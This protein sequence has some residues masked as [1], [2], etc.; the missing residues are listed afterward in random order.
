[1]PTYKILG[2]Y[3]FTKNLIEASLNDP[4]ILKHE[5]YNIKSKNAIGV[6]IKNDKKIGY[7]PIENNSELLNFKNS[8]KINKLQLNQDYALVEINRCYSNINTLENYEFSYIKK[9]KYNYEI[10]D[11][12][13][14]LI[15][16]LKN[17][18]NNLKHKRITAK[19]IA[20]IYLD[21]DFINLSIETNKGIETFYLISLKFFK[22]NEEKYEELLEFNLIEHTFFQELF[23]HRPEKYIEINYTNIL[24]SELPLN[25]CEFLKIQTCE[26]IN[27]TSYIDDIIYF[28]KLYIYCL[29]IN[30]FTYIIKYTKKNIDNDIN[31]SIIKN[32]F[33]EYKLNLGG[34][35][36]NHEKKIYSEIDFIND[37]SIFII[38]DNISKN[39]LLNYDLTDKKKILIYNP[40]E[41]VIYSL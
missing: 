20:I 2:I 35:Y 26:K 13:K 1:M 19:R 40:L 28:T 25:N 6:Y 31:L 41:G 18:L 17:V 10:I 38:S 30:D 7:L 36:Y 15:N 21:S 39:Y 29:C 22:E 5:K 33:E 37:D 14:N 12:P 9:I 8:Y 23:F 16:P 4:V 3:S 11:V 34:F 27:K 24:L 32:I